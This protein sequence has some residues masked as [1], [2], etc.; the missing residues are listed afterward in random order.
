MH[1]LGGVVGGLAALVAVKHGGEAA[2]HAVGDLGGPGLGPAGHQLAHN[3]VPVLP[4]AGPAELSSV[5]QGEGLAGIPYISK[6]QQE[7]RALCG[8]L[9]VLGSSLLNMLL[10]RRMHGL[11]LENRFLHVELS[12]DA[13]L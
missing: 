11:I 3:D 9:N 2:P 13:H 10:P 6:E 8:L 5:S 12:S 7:D 1:A 4:R